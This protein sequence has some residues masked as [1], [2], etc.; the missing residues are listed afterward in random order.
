MLTNNILPVL[1]GR[2][3]KTMY[4]YL[5]DPIKTRGCFNKKDSFMSKL[6]FSALQEVLNRKPV[7]IDF[8]KEKI[9]DYFGMNVFDRDKM[10]AYLSH[11]AFQRVIEAIDNGE[12]IER[13]YS[14]QVASGMKAWAVDKGATHYTHWFHPLTG[15]TAEKHDAFFEFNA[16]NSVIE[17][18]EGGHLV[19]QEPDASSLPNGGIRNTF[20]AR[21][22]T[23]WDPTSPAFIIDRT[24][25]IPTVFVSY[26]GDALDYKTPLLRAL[27]ALNGAATEVCSYFSKDVTSVSTNLG[28]EQEYFL[29]DKALYNAR[30]DI[31]LTGRTL[32]GHAS[33]KDQQL[34]DHYFGSIP[35]RVSAFMKDLEVECYKLGIPIKTRHNEVAP[36]QFECAPIFE[37]ANLAVDHNMLLMDVMDK[38]ASKHNFKVLLHEKPFKGINGSGKHNNFSMVTNTGINLL[39]P[40]KTPKKNM[41]FLTFLVNTIAAVYSHAELLYASIASIDNEHRLGGHEAP[42]SII[43]VFIGS[44]LT[45]ILDE[46]ENR[47]TDDK[48][49]PNEKA[50]LKLD[51]GRIPDILL[52]NT[53]RNR[54]SPFAFTGNRFEFRAP[55]SSVNCA[56]PMTVLT[57]AVASQLKT[58]AANVEKLVSQG[59]KRDE[60]IFQELRDTITAVKPILFEG[61]GYSFEWK[62]EAMKRGLPIFEGTLDPIKA[63]TT[64]K[65]EEL[66][67][68]QNILTSRELYARYKVRVDAYTK[69][70][71]IESRVLGDL[72]KNHIVPVALKYQ[73]SLIENIKGLKD[74]LPEREYNE[75]ASPEIDVIKDISYHI[76]YIKTNV[77]DMT[78]ARKVANA[79][80]DD[81]DKAYAYYGTVKPYLDKIRYHIDKLELTVD[82]E[83]W[84][85]PKYRELLFYR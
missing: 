78:E 46:L 32:M 17:S 73:N 36:N 7:T 40:G 77:K 63:F 33:A 59:I 26:T 50:E 56:A 20:E 82:N 22:Y 58:F 51:I 5:H 68:S 41:Q 53:D 10:R 21:G 75:I 18:F 44:T 12:P 30:P 34:S 67:I 23:A 13:K 38:V 24:L 8:P 80:T 84:P 9:S 65:T 55:G 15:T 48:M 29:I 47:I 64:P 28:W 76:A 3:L 45:E 11:D 57:A 27:N 72:T 69:R 70:L 6:R 2:I 79:I 60:A 31:Q 37:E 62:K 66:F 25:C 81:V 39:S 43:S 83:L 54:T 42:P 35:V 19:Q 14:D 85:L 49:T 71:Q 52:D 74:I 4:L 16:Q 61:D 1:R